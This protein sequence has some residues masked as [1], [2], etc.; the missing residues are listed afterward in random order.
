MVQR[1]LGRS[2]VL[3]ASGYR[4]CGAYRSSFTLDRCPLCGELEVTVLHPL[5]A[6]AGTADLHRRAAA[7]GGLPPRG[8]QQFLVLAL[9]GP[10]PTLDLRNVASNFVG[11]AL[12]RVLNAHLHGLQGPSAAEVEQLSSSRI[13]ALGC[14]LPGAV[15]PVEVEP[16]DL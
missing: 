9:F 7:A 11:A 5:V 13:D 10:A 12:G 6:C 3:R 2:R 15:D 8:H 4:L 14:H 16:D 1:L